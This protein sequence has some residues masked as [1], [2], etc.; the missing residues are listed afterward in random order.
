MRRTFVAIATIALGLG[1]L[2]VPS[3]SAGE[4]ECTGT[5][6]GGTITDNLVVRSGNDCRLD[7][8]QVLGNVRVEPNGALGIRGG[9]FH[10]NVNSD[11]ARWFFIDCSPGGCR[12]GGTPAVFHGNVQ[13]TGTT[14]RVRPEGY[15]NYICSAQISGQLQLFNNSGP[16]LIG[17]AE[18]TPGGSNSQWCAPNNP[19]NVGKQLHAEGNSHRVDISDVN[20]GDHLQI[21]NNVDTAGGGGTYVYDNDVTKFLQCS[22][23]APIQGGGNTAQKKQGQCAA[24]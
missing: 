5:V 8:V 22:G 10:K 11:G 1:V 4:V 20:V 24:F 9:T 2:M 3:A 6:T 14:D 18:P 21:L 15:D 23:N 19:M 7:N 13:F 16:L 12:G 17:N